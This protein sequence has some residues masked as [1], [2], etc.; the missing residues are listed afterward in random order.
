LIESSSPIVYLNERRTLNNEIVAPILNQR[1]VSECNNA[2]IKLL[3][4]FYDGTN[5]NNKNISLDKCKV[6]QLPKSKT[7]EKDSENLESTRSSS[8][9]CINSIFVNTYVDYCSKYGMGKNDNFF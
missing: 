1:R 5:V 9:G 3:K 4:H 2:D 8:R 6:K 7:I